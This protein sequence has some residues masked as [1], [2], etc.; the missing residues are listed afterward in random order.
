MRDYSIL[1]TIGWLQPERAG[2]I[3]WLVLLFGWL[4]YSVYQLTHVH[5]LLLAAPLW[6]VLLTWSMLHF[7]MAVR[8]IG[9][10]AAICLGISFLMPPSAVAFVLSLPWFVHCSELAVRCLRHW[11]IKKSF[12]T[13]RLCK[14]AALLFLSVGAAAA[15]ADRIDFQPFGFDAT[16]ILLTAAHFHYAGFCLPIIT[17]F[18]SLYFSKTI[19]QLVAGGVLIGMPFVALGI[20]ATQFHFPVFLE[21]ASVTWMV[22]AGLLVSFLHIRLGW[23][24]R[25]RFYGWLWLL[26]GCALCT[27]MTLAFLYGWRCYFPL[28]F[29]SIPFMYALHGTLNSVGFAALAL[30]GWY[31]AKKEERK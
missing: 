24:S 19:G 23:Q 27:G 2:F 1:H 10:V 11:W 26:A 5:I 30:L 9:L 15:V 7:S 31:V 14:V 13:D 16:L 28:P 4:P 20:T 21:I 3:I 25:N 6:L 29:L 8:W 22:L 17:S 12:A 18:I